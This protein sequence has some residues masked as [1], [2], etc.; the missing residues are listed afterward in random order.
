MPKTAQ[1]FA[2]Q[3]ARLSKEIEETNNKF[4]AQAKA[5]AIATAYANALTGIKTGDFKGFADLAKVAVE[6]SSNPFLRN[7]TEDAL[8]LG[9]T[10]AADY[11]RTE[12]LS[13]R[14]DLRFAT[15]NFR[16]DQAADFAAEND[17]RESDKQLKAQHEAQTF[18][19]SKAHNEAQN[20]YV[21]E[22]KGY[23]DAVANGVTGLNKP[24]PPQAPQPVPPP[25]YKSKEFGG[26]GAKSTVPRGTPVDAQGL[27]EAL[28]VAEGNPF[29]MAQGAPPP[30]PTQG[31]P[32][33]SVPAKPTPAPTPN[34]RQTV[35]ADMVKNKSKVE[36]ANSALAA[37]GEKPLSPA[38]Y[39]SFVN[40]KTPG[41][42]EIKVPPGYKKETVQIGDTN[43]HFIIPPPI[44]KVTK[45]IEVGGTK[46]KIPPQEN[47]DDP[48]V[49]VP[50]AA[51]L[52]AE[53]NQLDGKFMEW[54][55]NERMQKGVSGQGKQIRVSPNPSGK[56]GDPWTATS[57]GVLMSDKNPAAAEDKT[58]K[59]PRDT[60][61]MIP[62]AL[63]EKWVRLEV[64][65]PMV[66][67]YV[68]SD[69]APKPAPNDQQLSAA[70]DHVLG[71]YKA[72]KPTPEELNQQNAELKKIGA[73]PI[74]MEDITP[75]AKESG[76]DPELLKAKD[77]LIRLGVKGIPKDK[78]FV[79]AWQGVKNAVGSIS[80]AVIEYV[81][82]PKAGKET[83]QKSITHFEEILQS[84]SDN[85]TN[86]QKIRMANDIR[87]LREKLATAK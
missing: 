9:V 69:K 6:T 27:P 81:G 5:P 42:T 29:A 80:K 14:E 41:S 21:E 75:K 84:N 43:V 33:T 54:A 60:P 36:D 63:G 23:N 74:T 59:T 83:L 25:V 30:A 18:A 16:A 24:A 66:H 52:T 79:G 49:L 45:E 3:G 64:I 31:L 34:F 44:P 87:L 19:L 61:H 8:K 35:I 26:P 73:K 20:K 68:Q 4:E 82:T 17:L 77:E 72:N 71:L 55:K 51:K 13:K 86:Y 46:I 58:G 38:E 85:M 62:A 70:R 37:E 15:Q 47:K 12:A 57:D 11:A 22:L 1:L 78:E 50:E 10:A 32:E 28:P 40:E 76:P 39:Q 2:E 48:S 67:D 7:M 53:I 65:Q 56:K